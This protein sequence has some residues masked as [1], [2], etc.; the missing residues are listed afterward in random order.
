MAI[1]EQTI[2]RLYNSATG[3]WELVRS[4]VDPAVTA[5]GGTGIMAVGH[6]PGFN[7]TG[8]ASLGNSTG[9]SVT[10]STYGSDTIMWY[11]SQGSTGPMIFE[12]TVDNINWFTHPNVIETATGAD[13]DVWQTGTVS[14]ATGDIYRINGN[15]FHSVRLRRAHVGGATVTVSYVLSSGPTILKA[16]EMRSAPHL[17]GYVQVKKTAE[18]TSAQTG[19]TVWQ[20]ST[21]KRLAITDFNITT[22][23]L[24][25]GLVTMWCGTAGDTTYT[26]GT[27]ETVFRGE[28]APGTASR[29]GALKTYDVPWICSTAN[30]VLRF[31]SSANMT[32]YIQVNGYEF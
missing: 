29:P 25:A 27:D 28:F 6:G 17:F 12:A 1:V 23:G 7:L 20:P 22:G 15:G 11:L 2:V 8:T 16:S 21:G 24:T 18:F 14:G 4:T 10:I 13:Y 19:A 9:A 3:Q 5:I 30:N 32:V 26:A 31:T